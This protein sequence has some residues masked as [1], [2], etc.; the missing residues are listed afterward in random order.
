MKNGY[1]FW[2]FI[3]FVIKLLVFWK[4]TFKWAF[5]EDKLKTGEI[6]MHN[7]LALYIQTDPIQIQYTY[8][9]KKLQVAPLLCILHY[10]E[11]SALLSGE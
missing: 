3:R 9:L 5:N 11:N 6:S 7:Y 4:I 1:S 2:D 10:W 8:K